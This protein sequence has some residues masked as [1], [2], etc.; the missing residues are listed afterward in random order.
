MEFVGYDLLFSLVTLTFLEIILGIDNLIFIALV[1]HKLNKKHR[2]S[3]R[4]FGLSLALIIRIL[5]LLTL[6]WIMSL[7]EPLFYIFN[8]GFSFKNFLL[9]SGGLFLIVKSSWE[10]GNDL[11]AGPE[12][13]NK[14]S[15]STGAKKGFIAAVLQ[16]T[17]ID[18]VFSFDSVITAIGMTNNIPII[19]A[20]IIISMIVMLLSS[21]KISHFL[22]TYPS[23]KVV[24][25]A[26]IFLI[27]FILLAD[28]LHFHISKGYLYFALFFTLAVESINI[29]A[30]KKHKH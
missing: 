4:I 25:L 2:K 28:G 10:I 26:F 9:I 16:I 6:S 12:L 18:F 22:Q 29:V 19:V 13:I 21:E 20:A 5:M 17:L 27:G 24:A 11:I 1:V 3:A 30:R 7:T 23:L 15:N 8:T 14:N